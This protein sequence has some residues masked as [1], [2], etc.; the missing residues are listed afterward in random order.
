MAC[1]P[2]WGLLTGGGMEDKEHFRQ[3]NGQQQRS[4]KTWSRHTSGPD[5][6]EQE[7]VET[8]GYV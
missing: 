6:L 5:S 1:G 4:E 8:I 3:K 2:L 7:K